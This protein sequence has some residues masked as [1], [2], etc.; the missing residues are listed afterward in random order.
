M[1]EGLP[2]EGYR[3]QPRSNVELVNHNKQAEEIIL[4]NMDAM[5]NMEGVDQRWLAVARTQLEQAFMAWN[6]A[7]FRPG[8][9][10]L[11][12]DDAHP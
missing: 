9:I 6:R 4:R 5:R 3:P 11:D 2:V 10:A 1:M 8:R 7:I 12:G